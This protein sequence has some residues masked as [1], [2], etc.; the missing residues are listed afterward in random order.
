MLQEPE[1][2]EA[3]PGQGAPAG[4]ASAA[5]PLSP[6]LVLANCCLPVM[7][8]SAACR[9]L[10][11][12]WAAMQQEACVGPVEGMGC[13]GK[14]EILWGMAELWSGHMA[15]LVQDMGLLC[16]KP[17]ALAALASAPVADSEAAARPEPEAG[18][19]STGRVSESTGSAADSAPAPGLPGTAPMTTLHPAA[20]APA[21]SHT[22]TARD[23]HRSPEAR[24]A[25]MVAATRLL[26]FLAQHSMQ[27]VLEEVLEQAAALGLV[28]LHH[29]QLEA[30][31][32]RH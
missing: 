30:Q 18:G 4:A 3:G 14:P 22:P 24:A 5:A 1:L 31:G 8:S 23:L 25:L 29:Q 20:S 28:D 13:Q 6:P 7:S 27:A 12:L 15:A 10:Q 32:A 16:M 11:G 17:R 2:Q 21:P 9:E 19:A 26:V